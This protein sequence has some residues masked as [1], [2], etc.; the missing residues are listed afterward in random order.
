MP[1][2]AV[3]LSQ[4]TYADIMLLVSAGAYSGPEQFLEIAAF[5]QLALE[6]GLTP[7]ELLKTINR[8]ASARAGAFQSESS[9]T[10]AKPNRDDV[11][12][13]PRKRSAPVVGKAV[14]FPRGNEASVAEEEVSRTILHFSLQA[15]RN[16]KTELASQPTN[17]GNDRIWGQVNRLFP[18]KA[19]CRWIAA[20]A[21]SEGHWPSM[22]HAI[23]NLSPDA[24]VLG[25]A[26]EKAD[27]QN[28]RKRE[29]MM[30]IGLPRK[31]NIQSTDRFFSQF[32]GRST[33]TGRVYP[34]VIG[35]YGFA[36]VTTSCIQLTRWGFELACME[37][38]ILDA[39]LSTA[40]R[41]LSDEERAFILR[42][43]WERVPA[44]KQDLAVV[45]HKVADGNTRP[46][47]LLKQT[48]SKFPS[49]WTDVA[50]R[51][52]LYGIVARLGELGLVTKSWEGRS[53]EYKITDT[54]Q[55][56]L[57]A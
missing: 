35:Q 15:C 14:P 39:K 34:G 24:A 11:G 26:L 52:H 32:V 43:V 42:Q 5:N 51:T 40:K 47:S 41:T 1:V 50:F 46:E 21:N 20:S 38:P 10:I 18:L 12:A 6:R 45:L 16:L 22:A 7:E 4:K 27:S 30:G 17:T 9:A 53:V 19:A 28:A 25:S 54:A 48:R 31:G 36:S 37:N 57:A 3:N 23:E 49:N 29:E 56:I 55:R 33:R 13:Q 2:I 8:P 44:E